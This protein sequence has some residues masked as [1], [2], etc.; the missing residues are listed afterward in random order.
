MRMSPDVHH[1]AHECITR[2]C[3]MKRI[4]LR[5]LRPVEI[6]HV[7]ALNRL[8]QEGTPQSQYEQ[9]DDNKFPA[10]DIKIAECILRLREFRFSYLRDG[11]DRRLS[12]VPIR[13]LLVCIRNRQS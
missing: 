8:I 7:V 2:M 13:R 12:F 1:S 9:R 3:G 5:M 4:D 6:V 10:Q 11:R